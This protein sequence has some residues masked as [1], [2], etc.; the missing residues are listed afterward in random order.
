M[1]LK[2]LLIIIVGL[3]IVISV[4]L[5][6]HYSYRHYYFEP[7]LLVN[8]ERGN[9]FALEVNWSGAFCR[10]IPGTGMWCE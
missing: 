10:V 6:A 9:I 5:A 7:V 1:K 4:A 3:L 2:R 8:E